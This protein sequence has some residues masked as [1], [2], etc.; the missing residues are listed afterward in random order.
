MP[1]TVRSPG[2]HNWFRGGTLRTFDKETQRTLEEL[3]GLVDVELAR[4]IWAN[5]LDAPWDGVDRW[6]HGDVS[7]CDDHAPGRAS[8]SGAE[9]GRL[10]G[11]FRCPQRCTDHEYGKRRGR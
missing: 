4:E 10:R 7:Q 1:P 8:H 6:F 9:T 11:R 3:D 2:V 5:A